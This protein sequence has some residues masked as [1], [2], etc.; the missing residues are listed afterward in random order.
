MDGLL[1]ISYVTG[2]ILR[3]SRTRTASAG[4]QVAIVLRM[5][6]EKYWFLFGLKAKWISTS[7][8]ARLQGK[9]N[10]CSRG[11]NRLS[12]RAVSTFPTGIRAI[13]PPQGTPLHP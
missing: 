1:R 10:R 6:V 3:A 7:G 13:F 9:P 4:T 11:S 8:S 12:K 2:E 5:A